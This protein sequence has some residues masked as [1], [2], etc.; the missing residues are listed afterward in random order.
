[1]RTRFVVAVL[2]A[3]LF[4]AA[5]SWLG[6]ERSAVRARLEA[7]RKDVNIH[8]AEGLGTV[9]HAASLTSYFTEDVSIELGDGTAPVQGREMLLGMAARLH[10]RV[11]QFQLELA[12]INVQLAPDKKSADVNLTA[13]FIDR[14]PTT[15][16]SRD[17]RE[18]ALT[19]RLEDGEWRIARVV[20]VQTLK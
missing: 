8:A 5:C 6:D 9:T 20:A 2:L 11:A 19:M 7:F 17:A 14:T 3:L 18:F 13:E 12:D 10:A 1:M 15:R 16:R 4:Q